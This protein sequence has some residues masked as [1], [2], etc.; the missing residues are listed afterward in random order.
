MARVVMV[1]GAVLVACS[2][3][4]PAP[5]PVVESPAVWIPPPPPPPPTEAELGMARMRGEAD[6]LALYEGRA[7][8]AELAAWAESAANVRYGHLERDPRA[9]F[10]ERAVFSG[11]VEEIHDLPEG[12]TMLRVATAAYGADV[13][14]VETIVRPH[15]DVIAGTRVRVYGYL[16]GP[17]T[18]ESS[19]G[20]TI[21]VPSMLGVAV[22][23]RR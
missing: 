4:A 18:Y 3:P 11:R 9:H 6:H 23:R 16:A 13:I 1:L 2:G 21:T 22:V 15:E 19:A 7:L 20:W 8:T 10:G 5:A 17:H 12:G 14:W